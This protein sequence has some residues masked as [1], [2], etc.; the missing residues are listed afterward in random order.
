MK[1]TMRKLI[2]CVG[3]F[4]SL[5]LAAQAEQYWWAGNGNDLGGSGTWDLTSNNW[6][7]GSSTG[8]LTNWGNGTSDIAIFTNNTGAASGLTVTL[9]STPINVSG[10]YF[11]TNTVLT[12]G[13]LNFGSSGGVIDM[14]T[15]ASPAALPIIRSALAGSGNLTISGTTTAIKLL[16]NNTNFSGKI[17]IGGTKPSPA[18]MILVITNEFNLGAVPSVYTPDSITASG[19]VTAWLANDLNTASAVTISSNRGITLLQTLALCGKDINSGGLFNLNS[20]ITGPG[21]LSLYYPTTVA[22]FNQTN[23][24]AGNL[25]L[26]GCK[27]IMGVNNALPHGAGKGNIVFNYGGTIEM[28]GYDLTVNGFS[29]SQS[30]IVSVFCNNSVNPVTLSIGDGNTTATLNGVITNGAS[31]GAIS[32]EKI[33]TGT[34][35]L[36]PHSSN[37]TANAYSGTT[38][39][40][41]GSLVFDRLNKTNESL[42]GAVTLAGGTLSIYGAGATTNASQTFTSGTLPIMPGGNGLTVNNRGGNTTLTVGSTWTRTNGASLVVSLLGTGTSTLSSSPTL[43]NGIVGGY[44]FV[45]DNTDAGFATVVGGNVLRYTDVTLLDSTAAAAN[46]DGTKNYYMSGDQTLGGGALTQT[47]NSIRLNNVTLGLNNKVLVVGSGGIIFSNAVVN[48]IGSAAGNGTVTAPTGSDLVVYMFSSGSN[49]YRMNSN[50]ADNNGPVSLVIGSESGSS[51]RLGGNNTYSGDTIINGGGLQI[52]GIPY[53]SGKGNLVI[54]SGG[55]ADMA[56]SDARV[57]GLSASP[58]NAGGS[59]VNTYSTTATNTLT[60]GNGDATATYPGIISKGTTRTVVLIKVGTGTQTLSGANTYQGGTILSNGVLSVSSTNN[61]G[62]ANAKVTFAGG[63]LRISGTTFNSFGSMPLTFTSAGGGLDIADAGNSL[64]VTNN[65][66]SGSVFTKTGAGTLTLSGTQAGTINTD[67]SSKI[68][69]GSGL[70]FYNLG[71]ITGGVLSPT[72]SGMIGSLVVNNNLT[73]SG[74]LLVDVTASTNDMVT[75]SGTITLTGATLEIVNP[76]LLERSK[77]YTLMTAGG[78]AVSGSLT[79]LNLPD[80]WKV[81]TVGNTVV[82]YYSYPGTMIRFL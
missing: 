16:G 45:K 39:V 77:I 37:T 19:I 6:R 32:I 73:Q 9:G 27:A 47:V 81:V 31:N 58:G 62:G 70:S 75:A 2:G 38:V 18:Y 42:S 82:L 46:L 5:A 78:G 54:N 26:R 29:Y 79:A 51:L 8:T 56:S 63:T 44:A 11:C 35:T 64:T 67:D 3:L 22:T 25:T 66:A 10:I 34:T 36:Q 41:G 43:T 59:L 1:T 55:T 68:S 40:R 17:I 49:L 71:V 21:S 61:I 24:F 4:M 12:N 80:R 20:R 15:N 76:L 69:F 53:G 30:P 52:G 65:L 33:G 72:G 28:N 23:D 50:I 7:W 74:K 48:G 14:S 60:V 13:V 57:N